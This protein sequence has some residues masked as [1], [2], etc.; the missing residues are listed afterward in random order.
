MSDRDIQCDE[1][2]TKHIKR[3]AEGKKVK[4]IIRGRLEPPWIAPV[5][6]FLLLILGLLGW[7]GIEMYLFDYQYKVASLHTFVG[8]I[9]LLAVALHLTNNFFAI[10]GSTPRRPEG[11]L[12]WSHRRGVKAT[13]GLYAPDDDTQLADSVTAATSNTNF[14]LSS[15]FDASGDSRIRVML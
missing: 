14:I 3:T 9:F 15:G 5:T 1:R 10:D 7:T 11:L 4:R 6:S 8:S 2:T 13:D 12:V